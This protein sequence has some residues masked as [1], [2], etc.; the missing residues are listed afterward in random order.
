[1]ISNTDLSVKNIT[2]PFNLLKSPDMPVKALNLLE[3]QVGVIFFDIGLI[4]VLLI[5]LS[6]VFLTFQCF[7]VSFSLI[8]SRSRFTFNIVVVQVSGLYIIQEY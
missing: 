4:N 7:I 1:M 2:V 5:Y 6:F 8:S 3:D